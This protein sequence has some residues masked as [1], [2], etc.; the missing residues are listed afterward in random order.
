MLHTI[1]KSSFT[2]RVVD[3]WFQ[4]IDAQKDVLILIEDGVY[5][6][7]KSAPVAQFV[8]SLSQDHDE[9]HCGVFAL[10]KDIAARGLSADKLNPLVIMIDE[11]RF[12]E[13][14]VAHETSISWF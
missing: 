7:L 3:Q 4:R 13:L 5:N 2:H 1:N 9:E 11:D 14:C 10:E 12:V 8:R 6:A